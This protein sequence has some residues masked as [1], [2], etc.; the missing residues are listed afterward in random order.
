[1]LTE[2]ILPNPELVRKILIIYFETL[3]S[4]NAEER[5]RAPECASSKPPRALPVPKMGLII[6]PIFID[7]FFEVIDFLIEKV[8]TIECAV[9]SGFGLFFQ[10]SQNDWFLWPKSQRQ[11]L[12]LKY[13]VLANK[14]LDKCIQYFQGET[15]S[16]CIIKFNH[17][18]FSLT[19][20]AIFRHPRFM[21]KFMRDE[22]FGIEIHK[23]FD[24]L[25]NFCMNHNE[26]SRLN[27]SIMSTVIECFSCLTIL[28]KHKH[29]FAHFTRRYEGNF[30]WQ[31]IL[32]NYFTCLAS[33]R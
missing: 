23:L 30:F 14:Y 8:A 32:E 24:N 19:F 22:K 26:F 11:Q 21:L 3:S 5:S 9:L 10:S 13:F 33:L 25:Y 28:L 29:M 17:L 31:E 20:N 7:H 27:E 1:M 15:P 16:L 6:R 18:D 2:I 4:F 12:T